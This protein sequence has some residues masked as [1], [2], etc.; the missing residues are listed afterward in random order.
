MSTEEKVENAAVWQIL[1]NGTVRTTRI[2]TVRVTTPG[3]PEIQIRI[4]K[5]T[6]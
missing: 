6:N 4:W 5:A 2:R 1:P 3:F